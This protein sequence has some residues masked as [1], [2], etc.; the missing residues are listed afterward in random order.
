MLHI[1]SVPFTTFYFLDLSPEAWDFIKKSGF[2]G[3]IIPQEYGGYYNAVVFLTD[4]NLCIILGGLGF[5][6]HGHSQGTVCGG[7]E[8]EMLTHRF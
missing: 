3:M 2:L 1:S 6:A 7:C 8:L 4:D 5:S